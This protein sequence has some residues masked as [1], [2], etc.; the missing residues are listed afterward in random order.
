MRVIGGQLRG[1]RFTPPKSFSGRPT[2]DF[3]RESLFNILHHQ[4]DMEGLKVLDLFGGTGSVSYEFASRG[5]ASVLSV[6]KDRKASRFI[7]Q[8]IEDFQIDDIADVIAADV[9]GLMGNNI[10]S[11]DI[12]FA[13]PPFEHPQIA[14]LPNLLLQQSWLAPGGMIIVEHPPQLDFSKVPHFDRTR[15]YGQVCFSFFKP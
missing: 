12:I 10:G 4:M 1:R 6:E 14:N 11:Y 3:A 8:T 2:T 9:F 15:K 7:K 13:D 5:A